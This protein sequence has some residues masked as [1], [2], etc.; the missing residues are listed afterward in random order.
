LTQGK[1]D[2]IDNSI[3]RSV[4][5][6][7]LLAF[8]S[9]LAFVPQSAMAA[10][11]GAPYTNVDSRNDRGNDTGDSQ[12]EGL[13]QSQLDQNYWRDAQRPGGVPN[14]PYYAPQAAPR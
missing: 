11:A 1:N 6:G 10:H 9:G 2:E 3:D 7:T 14:P 12:I 8:A 5:S 13:N 4:L